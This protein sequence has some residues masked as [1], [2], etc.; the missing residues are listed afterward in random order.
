MSPRAAQ[1]LPATSPD[2]FGAAIGRALQGAGEV[3][4][5]EARQDFSI[6]KKLGQDREF[7]E[8]NRRF[9]A[10]REEAAALSR[11]AR[12]DAD[13]GHGAAMA[14]AWDKLRAKALDGIAD[15]EVRQRAEAAVDEFGLRF[16]NGEADHEVVA[17]SQR[18]VQAFGEALDI[19]ANRTRRLEN[20]DDWGTELKLQYDAVDALKTL[21]LAQR[22]KL[23]DEAEQVLA[24]AYL[25]GMIERDPEA[26]KAFIASGQFDAMLTPQLAERLRNAADVEIRRAEAKVEQEQRLAGAAFRKRVATVKE[27]ASQGIDVTDQL[28]ALRDEAAALGDSKLALDLD[29][30]VADNTFA[31]VYEGQ[32]PVQVERRIAELGRLENPGAEQQRELAWLKKHQGAL[33][34]GF[35]KDPVGFAMRQGGASAPPPIDFED[36]ATLAARG[37][38]ARTYAEA[39]GRPVQPLS[40]QEAANLRANYTSGT[41]GERGVMD[42]LVRMGPA[43]ARAAARQIAPQDEPLQVMVTLG[44]PVRDIALR[45]RDI[46]KQDRQFIAKALK[47]DFEL[48][49]GM[50]AID[51]EFTDATRGLGAARGKYI[52]TARRIM[53]GYMDRDGVPPSQE[54]WRQ[55]LHMALGGTGKPSGGDGGRGGLGRW[56]DDNWFVVPAGLTPR[57]FSAQLQQAMVSGRTRPVNPDG[58]PINHRAVVPVQVG[59]D[60]YQLRTRGGNVVKDGKGRDWTFEVRR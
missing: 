8:F 58:S 46:L 54:M 2:A 21:S 33:A 12:P 25:D 23:K 17:V 26:A 48:D 1:P 4:H 53:A 29:G 39:V 13:V 30:M 7:L 15:R 24:G 43:Q 42:L 16:R 37:Q 50:Q 36:P 32:T 22:D 27:L 57:E 49:E 18:N 6:K 31:K 3:A 5:S 19:A 40:A 34:K 55:S 28:A 10:V 41:A 56:T 14:A 52:D 51:R 35:D 38:W 45:G 47:D 9:G 60:R 11:T 20:L 59:P 44:K